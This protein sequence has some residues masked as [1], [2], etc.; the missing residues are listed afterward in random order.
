MTDLKNAEAERDRGS[1]WIR[2]EEG[3]AP[4]RYS[5]KD[6][7][8]KPEKPPGTREEGQ[9][10]RGTTGKSDDIILDGNQAGPK[11]GSLTLSGELLKFSVL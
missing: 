9:Q 6:K 1:V 4:N 2:E 5:Y 11:I 10:G 3:T 8:R 7:E